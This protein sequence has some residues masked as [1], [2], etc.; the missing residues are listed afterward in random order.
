M[1]K[2]INGIESE[3]YN[4]SVDFVGQF[5]GHESS[6]SL[7]I[8]NG[9]SDQF[10]ILSKMSKATRVSAQN[11]RGCNTRPTFPSDQYAPSR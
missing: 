6:Y 10:S 5:L 7:F 3:L 9:A 11:E 8:A 4:K 2:K 1:V